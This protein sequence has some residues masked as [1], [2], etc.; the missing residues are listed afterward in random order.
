MY[1]IF[2][3][4]NIGGKLLGKVRDG[5]L[6]FVKRLQWWDNHFSCL[7]FDCQDCEFDMNSFSGINSLSHPRLKDTTLAQSLKIKIGNIIQIMK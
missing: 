2:N 5:S 1:N 7:V 3:A 4:S 6:S